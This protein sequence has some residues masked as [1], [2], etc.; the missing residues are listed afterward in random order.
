MCGR[1]TSLRAAAPAGCCTGT[2]KNV[3]LPQLVARRCHGVAERYLL[4]VVPGGL[5][6]E[7]T[8]DRYGP[9]AHNVAMEYKPNKHAV[10]RLVPYS[11]HCSNVS[12]PRWARLSSKVVSISQG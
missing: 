9:H 12:K 1:H 10:V 8:T 4:P 6:C 7:R 2:L 11:D 5:A 3:S